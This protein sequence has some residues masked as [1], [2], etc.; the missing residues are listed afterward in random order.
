MSSYVW[1]TGQDRHKVDAV[2]L[3]QDL[4]SPYVSDSIS[5]TSATGTIAAIDVPAGSIVHK[6]GIWATTAIAGADIDLGDG[7]VV[8]RYLDG[9]TTVALNDIKCSGVAGAVGADPVMAHYYSSA[10]SIDVVINSTGSTGAFKVLL[11]IVTG[12]HHYI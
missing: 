1:P 12:K 3:E 7:V 11:G 4:N 10:D 8:D 9:V 2:K 5:A 6:S